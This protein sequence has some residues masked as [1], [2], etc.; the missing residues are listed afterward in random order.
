MKKFSALIAVAAL[1]ALLP[2][3]A[4]G[5]GAAGFPTWSQKLPAKGRFLVLPAFGGDAVL[6]KETGIVWETEPSTAFF[7]WFT[8]II[9]CHTLNV[10]GRRGWRLPTIEELT[11][12][13]DPSQPSFLPAGHP[14]TVL[15]DGYWSSTSNA[16]SAANAWVISLDDGSVGNG[17]GKSISLR[18]WCVR[19][20][21][22]FDGVQ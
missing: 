15:A 1:A 4:F 5:A 6:D 3:A 16:A 17:P 8:A 18:A 14:F 13:M 19:G 12:I 2:A 11:S 7:T 10:G 22:G 21:Q 20:A 9:H